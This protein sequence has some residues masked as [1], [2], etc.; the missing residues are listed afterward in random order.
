MGMFKNVKEK[1]N[2]TNSFSQR[3]YKNLLGI[4]S[5]NRSQE[6]HFGDKLS[7]WKHLAP[8]HSLPLLTFSLHPFTLNNITVRG[9][10]PW[11]SVPKAISPVTLFKI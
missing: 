7:A 4:L 6:F 9:L 2:G 11:E 3:Y 8:A 1:K 10:L 5:P